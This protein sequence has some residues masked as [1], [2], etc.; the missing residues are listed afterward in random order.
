MAE[1]RPNGLLQHLR[2]VAAVLK[3]RELSDREAFRLEEWDAGYAANVRG[4][5]SQRDRSDHQRKSAV[6]D[7]GDVFARRLL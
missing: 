5:G 3:K 6:M 7:S 2:N 4:A 1:E